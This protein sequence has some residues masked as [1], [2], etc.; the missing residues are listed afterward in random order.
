M[1]Q[2]KILNFSGNL[3]YYFVFILGLVYLP[4]S[5]ET[6]S[7]FT[8]FLSRSFK[9]TQSIKNY[10]SGVKSL[11]Y[12]LGYSVDH[13]NDFLINLGIKGIA[14]LNPHSVKQAEPI[15]PDILLKMAAKLNFT[16]TTDKVFWC[17]F[18]FAIFLFARKSN[19]VPTTKEDLKNKHFLMRKDVSVEANMLIISFRFSK[20][21][22]FGERILQTP[23]IEIEDSILC[24][25]KHF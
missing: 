23:L 21:I 25:V 14:R 20:T 6:L 18:L 2:Q 12:L 11:H 8:Q 16:C 5:T 22:Q 3:F 13:I 19:L 15:T 17:L 1:A 4:A 9:S 10:V 24:H 7:L